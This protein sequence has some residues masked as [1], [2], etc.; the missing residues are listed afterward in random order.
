MTDKGVDNHFT[1][2]HKHS[3]LLDDHVLKRFASLI[4][5]ELVQAS[6]KAINFES[7]LTFIQSHK[8]IYIASLRSA[9]ML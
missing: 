6:I 7:F 9:I 2:T 8:N 1:N 3:H 4:L 5:L